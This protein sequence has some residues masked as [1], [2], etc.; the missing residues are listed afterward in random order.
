M[1]MNGSMLTRLKKYKKAIIEVEALKLETKRQTC[2]TTLNCR[3]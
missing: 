3:E 2:Q 1:F